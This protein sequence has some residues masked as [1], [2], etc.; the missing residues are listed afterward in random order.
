MLDEA[1]SPADSAPPGGRDAPP[2]RATGPVIRRVRLRGW[3]RTEPTT[4]VVA[5]PASPEQA[6]AVMSAATERGLIA[7]GLGRAY[8]N[9]AQND[10]GLVLATTKLNRIISLDAQDGLSVCEAGVSLQ[11]LMVAALPAGW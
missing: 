3:G 10:G 4:A 1:G 8:N 5:V 6:A 2:N 11:Q 7:R 9:A